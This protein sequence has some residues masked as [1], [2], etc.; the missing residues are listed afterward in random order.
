MNRA[1]FSG[2]AGM[3][4]HQTKMDV[5]GN[6]IANVNTYGYKSQRAVFS[7]I[8]YQTLRGASGGTAGRGG[9]NPSM[10]GYGSSLL[11]VQSQMTQSSMQN[12][13]FGMDVAIIA[14][15]GY[16]QVQDPT[17]IFSTPRP[18]CSAMTPTATW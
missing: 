12:T 13:G 18:V 14:G 5:I 8:Y 7:D 10:V 16:L 11:G 3:K 2:V 6:N 9:T 4:S 15:E 17:A 1:M